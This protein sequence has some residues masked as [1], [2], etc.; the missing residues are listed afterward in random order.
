MSNMYAIKEE[1]L[2]A[3]GDAIRGKANGTSELP[4]LNVEN[5]Y[6]MYSNAFPYSLPDYVKKVKITGVIDFSPFIGGNTAPSNGTQGLGMAS[7]KFSSIDPRG[8]RN[9]ESYRV[10]FEGYGSNAEMLSKTIEFET[11][12]EGNQ[13]T[14]VST[15]D[16]S[17]PS[18]FNLTFTAVGLDENGNEFKYTPLEMVDKINGIEAKDNTV[19]LGTINRSITE[20]TAKDLEGITR[21]GDYA[22]FNCSYLIN[23]EIPETVTSVGNYAFA[24]CRQL[25]NLYFPNASS[26]GCLVISSC[27]MRNI[28]LG[29]DGVVNINHDTFKT[30]ITSYTPSIEVPGHRYDE[31]CA[32]VTWN[33]NYLNQLVPY[34]KYVSIPKAMTMLFNQTKTITLDLQCFDEAPTN[35]TIVPNS[36]AISVSNISVT[37]TAITFDVSTA[38]IVGEA[39]ITITVPGD[40]GYVF[41]RECLINVFAQIEESTYEVVDLDLTSATN[42]YPFILGDDGYYESTNQKQNSSF[43][44]CQ[45]NINNLMNRTVYFDCISN[46][47][48]NYDYGILSKP[49]VELTKSEAAEDNSRPYDVAYHFKGKSSTN[50][51]T[52]EYN[53]ANGNCFIQVKYR[54]DGSGDQGTDNFKFKVRF[55]EIEV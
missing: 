40:D 30:N 34:T 46:G 29:Y 47:E 32:N 5:Q 11:I 26:F 17:S 45:V 53:N 10:L 54:K 49:N 38:E 16:S 33:S 37:N 25:N 28:R 21:I 18:G 2:S 51:Q 4:I 20:I 43:S 9:D 22:F 36:E 15:V 19:F 8:V 55:S 44:I 7:R 1:T 52:V 23:I 24:S 48:S 13:W 12:I 42:G 50:I 3:L 41:T 39:F 35:F 14:F 6:I 31:Y 27:S